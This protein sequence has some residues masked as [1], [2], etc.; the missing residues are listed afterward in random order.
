MPRPLDREDLRS[1]RDVTT[2]VC[3]KC[4]EGCPS[5]V[6]TVQPSSSTITRWAP[7]FTIGSIA[8][9]IPSSSTIPVPGLPKFGTAGSSCRASSRCRARRGPAP[10]KIRPPRHAAGRRRK[11]RGGGSRRRACSIPFIQRFLGDA[12]QPRLF[13]ADRADGERPRPVPEISVLLDAH[14][15]RDDLALFQDPAVGDAVDHLVVD[16][17]AERRREQVPLVVPYP[18]KAGIAAARPDDTPPPPRPARGRHAR[19]HERTRRVAAPPRRS[20]SF[21]S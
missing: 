10:P 19:L 21:P 4:A 12:H 17:D 5:A 7:P 8:S 2:T 14:V 1:R 20:S 9:A 15:D 13:R 6:L 18:L 11:C 3:S 16:R